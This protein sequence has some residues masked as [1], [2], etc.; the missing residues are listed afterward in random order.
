MVEVRGLKQRGVDL[1][2]RAGAVD[3]DHRQLK[4]LENEI[5]Q[6]IVLIDRLLSELSTDIA[7]D[8][9]LLA[10]VDNATDKDYESVLGYAT[11]GRSFYLGLS[12]SPR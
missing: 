10:R 3:E 5:N 8:W 7:R 1:R 2:R 9:R 6:S 11:A 4:I 12:W